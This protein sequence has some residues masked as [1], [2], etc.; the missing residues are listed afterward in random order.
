MTRMKRLSVL[1]VLTLTGLLANARPA[2]ADITAFLGINPTPATRIARGTAFGI[3]MVIVGFELEISNTTQD[4]D[5]AAPGLTTRMLNGLLITP[6]GATQLYL[7]AGGGWYTETLGSRQE[8]GLATNVGGGIKLKLAGPLRLRLDFRIFHLNDEALH[9]NP[10]RM[11]AGIN[12]R[13]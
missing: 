3:N 1:A 7:T 5:N 9:R 12:L 6:T 13:F 10:K 8:S 11:Y 4:E 2:A